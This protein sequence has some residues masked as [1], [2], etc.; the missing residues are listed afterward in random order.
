MNKRVK[1]KN[2]EKDEKALN[3]NYGHIWRVNLGIQK[4]SRP[5]FCDVLKSPIWII[6]LGI[7]FL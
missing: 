3:N 1:Q 7:T 4:K 2:I 5:I 6:Y